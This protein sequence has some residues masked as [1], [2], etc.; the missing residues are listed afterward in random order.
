MREAANKIILIDGECNLCNGALRFIE[1]RLR[2]DDCYYANLQSE[3]GQKLKNIHGLPEEINTVV[4]IINEKAYQKS[5]AALQIAKLLKFPYF[6]LPVFLLVPP[7]I[8]DFVYDYIASNRYKWF[9]KKTICE[10]PS[11]NFK[12]RLLK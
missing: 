7:T 5:S 6:L 4:F 10:I 3:V 2:T 11:P 1:K 12:M 8:R 9:G